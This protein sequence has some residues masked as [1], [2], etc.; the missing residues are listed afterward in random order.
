MRVR[1]GWKDLVEDEMWG[2]LRGGMSRKLV[3]WVEISDV[4]WWARARDEEVGGDAILMGVN[5]SYFS[6][7]GLDAPVERVSWYDAAW[8]TNKLSAL[9][10]LSGCF[11]GSGE[12]MAG[13]G[14]GGSDY[15]GCKGWRL[16]T[17]AE[18][19]YAARA[20]TTA[21]RYGELENIAW[22]DGN[23]GDTT[24]PVGGKQT[25]AWG[26]HD[27]LGNVCEWVYDRYD[28]SAY[29][30]SGQAAIDL[31]QAATGDSRVV[32]GGCWYNYA[33]YVRAAFRDYYAP[34]ARGNGYVGFR[35]FRSSP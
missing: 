10:G 19:E 23:S 15:L 20:G 31:V 32:R 4:L 11:V 18:W 9:E 5:P 6:K 28:A 13:V 14:N 21:P 34:S 27:M 8:F 35:L 33:Q 3:D 22:Y 17:E 25:N 29:K 2:Y 24:H 12:Q 16:P 30:R 1:E 7:V 26:L